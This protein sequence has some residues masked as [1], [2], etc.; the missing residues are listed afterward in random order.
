M[1]YKV[2]MEIEIS[3]ESESGVEARN[4]AA[5]VIKSLGIE[6]FAVLEAERVGGD[7]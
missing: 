7:E 4:Y 3:V 6:N 2:K 5:D 1:I